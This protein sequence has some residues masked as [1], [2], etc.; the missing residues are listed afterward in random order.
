MLISLPLYLLYEISIFISSVVV[1]NKRKQNEED[2]R[3]ETA[4]A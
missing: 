3:A 2:E 1:R 4:N